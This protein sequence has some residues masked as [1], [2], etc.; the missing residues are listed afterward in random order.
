[1]LSRDDSPLAQDAQSAMRAAARY[2]LQETALGAT[3][4]EI[5][6][7]LED[8]G[9]FLPDPEGFVEAAMKKSGGDPTFTAPVQDSEESFAN[10]AML[11]GA[12]LA[13]ALA[14]S[15]IVAFGVEAGGNFLQ[16]GFAGT[17]G[18]VFGCL[19]GAY[20]TFWS[21]DRDLKPLFCGALTGNF[22]FIFSLLVV[23]FLLE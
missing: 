3:K 2:V 17:G 19:A 9:I 23:I 8:L 10:R 11:F 14:L 1:M 6:Q 4:K 13:A 18:K 20:V 22:T 5:L 12:G 21:K 16:L 15:W 7:G